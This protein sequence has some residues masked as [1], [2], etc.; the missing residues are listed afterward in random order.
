MTI[1]ADSAASNGRLRASSGTQPPALT[2][3]R[4]APGAGST[5]WRSSACSDEGGRA[6]EERGCAAGA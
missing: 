3:L 5:V 1:T 2:P 4:A 6:R